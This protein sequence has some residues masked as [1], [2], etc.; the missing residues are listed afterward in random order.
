MGCTV[1]RKFIRGAVQNA[2]STLRPFIS[3]SIFPSQLVERVCEVTFF[4]VESETSQGFF[5][6]AGYTEIGAFGSSERLPILTPAPIH[7][8]PSWLSS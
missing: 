8:G 6:S 1:Y 2:E 7:P 4:Y 5:R 3:Q